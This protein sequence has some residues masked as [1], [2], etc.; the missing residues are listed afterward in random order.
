M[1]SK[2]STLLWAIIAVV[3][4]IT[5]VCAINTIICYYVPSLKHYLMIVYIPILVWVMYDAL[6]DKKR[7]FFISYNTTNG[8]GQICMSF[9]Y[10]VSNQITDY[11]EKLL[12][13]EI[14]ITNVIE[15]TKKEYELN[16]QYTGNKLQDK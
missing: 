16:K 2:L 15:I 8:V 4:I 7:Y 14:I 11:L 1:K 12:G 6:R 13:T 3:G 10:F 9:T 5:I